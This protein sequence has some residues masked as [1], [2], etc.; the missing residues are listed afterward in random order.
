MGYYTTFKLDLESKVE[1]NREEIIEAFRD[2]CDY[3]SCAL[4][5]EGH[6]ND[7]VKWYEHEEDL[8]SF[9]KSYHY[10]TF[11]LTGRGEDEDDYWQLVVL[12]GEATRNKLVNRKAFPI[13]TMNCTAEGFSYDNLKLVKKDNAIKI[14]IDNKQI[15]TVSSEQILIA[16]RSLITYQN[17]NSES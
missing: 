17:F 2:G 11:I 8:V 1:I 9:S 12:N 6:T 13:P 7:S 16:I 3:A 14:Y 4:D 15:A 5:Y 10:V